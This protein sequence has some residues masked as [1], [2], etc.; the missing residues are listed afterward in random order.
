[1]EAK[2]FLSEFKRMCNNSTCGGCEFFGKY[3]EYPEIDGSTDAAV[4]AVEA[5]SK[6]HPIV[7]NAAKLKEVFSITFDTLP[8]GDSRIYQ[9]GKF[10]RFEDWLNAEYKEV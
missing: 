6:E 10:M 9:N 4:D 8:N 7:T 3:C 2:V 1:M 5:W